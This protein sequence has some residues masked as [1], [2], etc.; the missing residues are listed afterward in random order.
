MEI[1]QQILTK[2]E[3]LFMR[4]GLKSITMD[5]LAR[6]LGMSKKTLYQYID[7]K[8]DLIA[9]LFQLRIDEEREMME[10]FQKQ[11]TDAIDEILHLARYIIRKLRQL[12]PTVV[13][14][15]QKYY[16]STWKE[17]EALHQKHVYH[18]IKENIERGIGQGVYRDDI[19]PD[20]IAKLYVGKTSL[21]ADEDLFPL[22]DYDISEL[23]KEYMLYHLHGIASAKGLALLEE[24]LA[25]SKEE[26]N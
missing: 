23:F 7:N 11:A 21:V 14:D 12:S 17:M 18:I 10:T 25:E 15:L 6:E 8:A 16:R 22:R 5:D 1:K 24:H 9:Q 4:Y 20:I 2:A 19:H 26:M 13:Y 3:A